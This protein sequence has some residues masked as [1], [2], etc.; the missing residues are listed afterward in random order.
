MR[1]ALAIVLVLSTSSN[2]FPC[3]PNQYG[4]SISSPINLI[5]RSTAIYYALATKGE[6]ITK[7]ATLQCSDETPSDDK[8]SSLDELLCRVNNAMLYP[9]ETTYVFDVIETIKGEHREEISIS[10]QASFVDYNPSTFNDHQDEEF[11]TAFGG[12]IGI[13]GDCD[14]KPKFALRERYLIVIVD[15]F[16]VKAFEK[17]NSEDDDWLLFVREHAE[18]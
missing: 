8:A 1:L 17:I 10:T 13:Y 6:L 12:R 4:P 18:D 3:W 14:I 5:K 15:G 9:T 7:Q 2:A 11:W 16:H